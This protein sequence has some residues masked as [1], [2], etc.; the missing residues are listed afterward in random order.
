MKHVSI[1][2]RNAVWLTLQPLVTG[3]LSIVV[4][5]LVA[6]YLGT[7]GYGELL[8]M[9]SYVALFAPLGS[10]GLRPYSVRE[11]AANPERALQI[12]EEMV[13]LR[14]A[15]AV[16]AVAISAAFL[17]LVP[18]QVPRS[19][20]V[21]FAFQVFFNAMSTTFIDGLYGIERMKPAATVMLLA[22][23]VVQIGCIV[24]VLLNGGLLGVAMA[25][26]LGGVATFVLAWWYFLREAGKVRLRL[27]G[28][29]DL[30]HIHASWAFF[31]QNVVTIVRSRIDVIVINSML[32]TH[33]AGLY[34]SAR[35]LLYRLEF[36]WDGIGTALFPRLAQLHGRDDAE[37][38]RLLRAAFKTGLVIS[39]PIAVGLFQTSDEIVD[40]VFGADYAESSRLLWILGLGLPM[41]FSHAVMFNTLRAMALE[42]ELLVMAAGGAVLSLVLL[43]LGI[44]L[45]GMEGAAIAA[46]TVF[47]AL[48]AASTVLYV[49]RLGSPLAAADA[50]KLVAANVF[51]GA[52]LY[53]S[54]EMHLVF[55]LLGGIL[56]FSTAVIALRLASWRAI[57]AVLGRKEPAADQD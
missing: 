43:I 5:A 47:G 30:R 36:L 8:L 9:L 33:A 56:S 40:L 14:F 17:E 57:R 50:A 25:Y 12:V 7:E 10:L 35:T 38:H 26:T 3:I 28:G 44:R 34:G 29:G 4:T 42:R 15:L 21:L 49:R 18:D 37:F 53:L 51:M 48:L 11:I 31:L 39:T 13:A 24:A 52:V 1:V 23:F 55:Q 19:L 16:V 32:G 6:R 54:H 46:T 20:Q 45:L 2:A 22:G 41:L 27:P